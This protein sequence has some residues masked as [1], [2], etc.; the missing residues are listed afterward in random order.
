MLQD[1]SFGRLENEFRNILPEV[2]D[3]VVCIR[4]NGILMT[5]DE[6]G[7]LTFPACAQVRSWA[8]TWD[9]WEGETLRYVFRMQEKNY[10]LWMGD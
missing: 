1:L 4:G 6:D 7:K 10:F 3:L 5:R 9:H 8:E 2:G